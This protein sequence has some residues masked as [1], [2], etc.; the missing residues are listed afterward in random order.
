MFNP[1]V[2]LDLNVSVSLGA[3]LRWDRIVLPHRDTFCTWIWMEANGKMI[4]NCTICVHI[5]IPMK[6]KRLWIKCSMID[7]HSS[8]SNWAHMCA[9]KRRKKE[10]IVRCHLHRRNREKRKIR[11]G[12]D[13]TKKT[14]AFQSSRHVCLFVCMWDVTIPVQRIV[15]FCSFIFICHRLAPFHISS[16]RKPLKSIICDNRQCLVYFW[17]KNTTNTQLNYIHMRHARL[18]QMESWTDFTTFK[19][20]NPNANSIFGIRFNWR[21]MVIFLSAVKRSINA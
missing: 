16:E 21:K 18:W 4:N 20:T 3:V 1:S 9:I 14:I 19:R 13:W 10:K 2:S 6:T 7:E 5:H 12:K 11:H 15:F 8:H 17:G